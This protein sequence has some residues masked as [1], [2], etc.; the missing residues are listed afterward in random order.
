MICLDVGHKWGSYSNFTLAFPTSV[1][2][3]SSMPL[4]GQLIG[5]VYPA[6]GSML[7][8]IEFLNDSN[9]P[10][11]SAKEPVCKGNIPTLLESGHDARRLEWY[12][13]IC[14]VAGSPSAGSS[15]KFHVNR[16]GHS[17][18]G[19]LTNVGSSFWSPVQ[20]SSLECWSIEPQ[21]CS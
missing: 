5:W 18:C 4:V 14:L 12:A 8:C 13:Y 21:A 17:Q 2:F 7:V 15:L 11:I 20:D 3:N 19:G 16:V 9:P 1:M 10:C 6:W